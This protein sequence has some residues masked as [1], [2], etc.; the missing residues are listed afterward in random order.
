MLDQK[1]KQRFFEKVVRTKSCWHW[2]ASLSKDG[3]GKFKM[4]YEVIG[5]HRVSWVIYNGPIKNKLFVLHKCN[6]RKCVNPKHLYLGTDKDNVRDAMKCGSHSAAK[7]KLRTHCMRGH[8]LSGTNLV[9]SGVKR[10]CRNC[11]AFRGRRIYHARA[12]RTPNG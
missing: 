5:A 11:R 4:A 3:Y 1:V 8:P 2:T 12:R 10:I 9:L 6:V 7:K